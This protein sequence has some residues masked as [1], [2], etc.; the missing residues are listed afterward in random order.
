MPPRRQP[1]HRGRVQ[2]V[3][4]RQP[5]LDRYIDDEALHAP[6]FVLM[7]TDVGID[8]ILIADVAD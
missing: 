1:I 2:R 4:F 6:M 7:N 5:G 8:V 3:C